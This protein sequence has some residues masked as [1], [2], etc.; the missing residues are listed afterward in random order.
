MPISPRIHELI[1]LLHVLD[2]DSL[3]AVDLEQLEKLCFKLAPRIRRK[4][5]K[6]A[7][8]GPIRLWTSRGR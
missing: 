1:T 8:A 3:N 2:L 7:N 6:L 5:E 4:R